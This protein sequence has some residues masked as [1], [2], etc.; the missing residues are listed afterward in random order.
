MVERDADLVFLGGRVETIIPRSVPAD[1]VAVRDGRIVA[2]GTRAD[3]RPLLGART[4]VLELHGE[5]LLPGFGDAHIHPIDGGMLSDRCDL[6]DLTDAP[7]YL[8]AIAGYAAA[9][10]RAT[11]GARRRLVVERLPPG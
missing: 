6:H 10:S 1:A 2:V 3:V 4:E 8:E 11:L 7:A 5:T 9:A